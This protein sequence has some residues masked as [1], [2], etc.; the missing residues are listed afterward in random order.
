MFLQ[1][2]SSFK[3]VS[4]MK[5][6]VHFHALLLT[7]FLLSAV[8]CLGFAATPTLGQLAITITSDN[9]NPTIGCQADNTVTYTVSVCNKSLTIGYYY[10]LTV[11]SPLDRQAISAYDPLLQLT[12]VSPTLEQLTGSFYIYPGNCAS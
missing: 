11:N 9:P 7:R 12:Q 5:K 10:D 3:L 4:I 6:L 1:I 2:F 8:L